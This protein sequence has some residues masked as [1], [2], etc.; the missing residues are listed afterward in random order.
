MKKILLVAALLIA[1]ATVNAQSRWAG[2]FRPVEL[3]KDRALTSEFKWRPAATIAATTFRWDEGVKASFLS[4]TGAGLSFA[5]YII[6]DDELYNNYSI[7]G[8]MLFPTEGDTYISLV[9]TASTMQY[10][11][12]GV[13]Y[14]VIPDNPVFKNFFLMTGITFVF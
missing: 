6:V 4:K 11:S 8:M 14:D 5:H 12:F 10:L 13:G 1:V 7:N 3:N 2:F 9:V